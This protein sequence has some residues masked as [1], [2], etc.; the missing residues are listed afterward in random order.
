MK[1]NTIEVVY[2]PSVYSICEIFKAKLG[3]FIVVQWVKNLTAVARVAEEA[4]VRLL[5]QDSGLKGPLL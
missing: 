5:A 2:M 4:Q 3:V 1:Y